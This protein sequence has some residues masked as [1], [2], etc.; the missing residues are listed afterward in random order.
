MKKGLLIIL[1]FVSFDGLGQ[2]PGVSISTQSEID[3][4]A[5]NYPGCSEFEFI[6][7]EGSQSTITNLSSLNQIEI[8]TNEFYVEVTDIIDFTGLEN[9]GFIGGEIFISGNYSLI[10]FNGLS[11]LQSIGGA[12]SSYNN[13]EQQDF[14]GLNSLSQINARFQSVGNLSLQ[15]FHGLENV[16]DVNGSLFIVRNDLLINLQGFDQLVSLGGTFSIDHNQNLID[17]T[18]LNNLSSI[19]GQF[20]ITDNP[21]LQTLNGLEHLETL[22]SAENNFHIFGNEN[23]IS[24]DAL[25]NLDLSNIEAIGIY[26]NLNLSNC[27]I[28]SICNALDNNFT[29]F[30]IQNNKTECNSIPEVEAQCQLSITEADI[31]QALSVFPNPVSSTLQINTSKTISFEKATVYSIL[32]EKILETSE[33]QL[34]L[35]NLSEGIY[36]VKVETDQ[37]SVTKKIVKE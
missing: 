6:R 17:L 32:G 15:S 24:I 14:S 10:N 2:C 1:L 19:G 3:N 36:F 28:N 20:Q 22:G 9:L 11:N 4:F 33:K 21:N 5:A 29:N 23:L 13:I 31:S 35:E 25:E 26:D 7:I 16:V 34:N 30:Y 8:I 27:A 18:G 12:F 37:G